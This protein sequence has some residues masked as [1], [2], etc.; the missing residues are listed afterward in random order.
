MIPRAPVAIFWWTVYFLLL[1]WEL[2]KPQPGWW[3]IAAWTASAL[4]EAFVYRRELLR[5]DA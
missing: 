4:I 1:F 5:E 2:G 3:W